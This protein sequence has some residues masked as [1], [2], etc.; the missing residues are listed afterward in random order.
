[1][2]KFPKPQIA[3][4][5]ALRAAFVREAW[6]GARVHNPAVGR[7][8][9]NCRQLRQSCLYTVMPLY[10]GELLETRLSRSP[11]LGLEEGRGIAIAL[12]RAAGALHRA[13]I[14]HRDIKPDNV[15]LEGGGR[16][17]LIDLGV[18][19]VPGLE[20]FPA[21]AIPGTKAYMAPEMAGGEPGN[22]LTD[23]SSLSASRCSAPL[24]GEYPYANADAMSPPRRK[25]PNSLR[26]IAP[27]PARPWLDA[28]LACAIAP[29]PERRYDDMIEF[30]LVLEAGPARSQTDSRP[31]TN[32]VRT[33]SA[34]GLA[35]A[36][37]R[38]SALALL[39]SLAMRW[40]H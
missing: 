33:R 24:P 13:G 2:L 4:V 6:V 1:M 40:P 3:S 19:R 27:G 36:S 22:E 21:D 39:A 9:S 8:C 18:V 30:A 32:L 31:E 15:I 35:S 10:Q 34:P 38:S 16:L 12:A 28:A 20:D 11:S 5:E 23:I 7:V 29:D 37:P 17:K 26:R 25:R 14:I